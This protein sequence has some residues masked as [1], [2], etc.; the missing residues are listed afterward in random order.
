MEDS[1]KLE[2]LMNKL[3]SRSAKLS[4]AL[5]VDGTVLSHHCYEIHNETEQYRG[6]LKVSL[7]AGVTSI[8]HINV[9]K[10]EN[11]KEALMFPGVIHIKQKHF[12]A[13]NEL[14]LNVNAAKKNI[15]DFLS[16]KSKTARIKGSNKIT[17]NP[18]MFENYPM[19]N[20]LQVYR[21]I[22]LIAQPLE[23]VSF[24]W[25]KKTGYTKVARDQAIRTIQGM[26]LSP[27]P[28]EV[29]AKEWQKDLESAM[30]QLESKSSDY[31]VTRIKD[32]YPKPSLKLKFF[33]ILQ[34]K[35]VYSATPAIVFT[36]DDAALC[37][38]KELSLIETKQRKAT[39]NKL[40]TGWDMISRFAPFYIK[41]S[42]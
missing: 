8:F 6:E 24:I 28:L 37:L 38:A 3:A 4:E 36:D 9:D 39:L 29:S 19:V 23:K 17:S 13:I 2:D 5:L 25:R 14:V 32:G 21:K 16:S 12:N 10:P 33:D 42:T 20:T 27:A 15:K 40:V 11:T 31:V 7:E 22:S 26:Y 34:W 1:K 35:E 30:S 18:L 41:S